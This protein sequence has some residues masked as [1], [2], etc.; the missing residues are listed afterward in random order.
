MK[1]RIIYFIVML[2]TSSL[3]SACDVLSGLGKDNA[4]PPTALVNFQPQMQMQSDWARSVG[5][6]VG[7]DYLKLGPVL[8][9]RIFVADPNGSVVAFDARTGSRLWQTNTKAPLTSGPSIG[10]GLVVL[11]TSDAQVIALNE[12]SGL[13][14]WRTTVPNALLA[15]P[16][17]ADK[18]YVR[19]V[20]G[21]LVALSL[22][23]GQL[24]WRYD[25]GASL[26][27]LRVNSM[28]KVAGNKV[29][30]GFADGKL[31]AYST[32]QGNLLWEQIIATPQGVT[33][34]QQMVD[35]VAD[36]IIANGIIYVAT[37][38]G[39][40]AAVNLANGN[41]IWQRNISTYTGLALGPK[42]LFVTDAQGTI[43]AFNRVTGDVVWRQTQ[44]NYRGLTAPAL[45]NG[46]VVVADSKGYI[47]IV[48]QTDGHML[49]RAYT[50]NSNGIVAPPV[51]SGNTIYV[52]TTTGTL[53]T[54]VVS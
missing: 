16:Q 1:N 28:P 34:A 52:V 36:P 2:V 10:N 50:G 47:H 20:D 45:I 18:V 27:T 37:Y 39:K 7:K 11:G 53:M 51:A 38:Q 30:A 15:A 22:Q 4:P 32:S 29:I 12:A 48:S 8:D 17:V 44:L 24:V 9:G 43:W 41:I 21:K 54:W 13:L 26:L 46:G 25:H 40:I 6:G 5:A 14:V 19:T 33:D 35:V 31:G 23:N 3:L 49:A 42:L